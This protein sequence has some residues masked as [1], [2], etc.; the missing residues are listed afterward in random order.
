MGPVLFGAVTEARSAL[1]NSALTL[2][3][4][5]VLGAPQAKLR[6][7]WFGE[8]VPLADVF[9]VLTRLLPRA[10]RAG[11]GVNLQRVG[12]ARIGVVN[13]YEDTLP[14]TTRQIALARPNLLVSV[15]NDAWFV[16]SWEPE[17]HLRLAAVRAVESRLDLVR[18]VNGAGATWVDASGRIR[19]RG[20]TVL[21]DAL[22][23]TPA[24]L[25]H[26]PTW[27]VRFGN[28]P[29]WLVIVSLGCVF[30]LRALRN[31]TPNS[32]RAERHLPGDG[33]RLAARASR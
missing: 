21:E 6:P 26:P 22:I 20:S 14:D 31:A 11:Q 4:N 17:L 28:T 10:I 27:F 9:P 7:L 18:A 1:Y 13:C 24:L 8:A 3:R 5:G 16:D 32:A 19:A 23:V 29:L 30:R 33:G 15:T 2:D 12:Q 25:E